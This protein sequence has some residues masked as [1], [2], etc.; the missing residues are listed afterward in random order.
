MRRPQESPVKSRQPTSDA[1]QV[2]RNTIS[3]WAVTIIVLLF[4]WSSLLQAFIIPSSSMES[5]L[6]VGDHVLVDRLCYAPAGT[7]SQH[8]LPYSKVRRG[9]IVVFRWPVDISQN[10]V[11]RAIGLPGDRLRIVNKQVY[12][13][14]KPLTEP[15]TQF[16]TSFIVPYRDNFPAEPDPSADQRAREMLEQ[17]VVNGELVIPAGKYFMMGDNRDNSLDSRYWGFVPADN[18]VGKPTIIFWSYEAPTEHLTSFFSLD[19]AI[20]L[21]QNFF[22]KTRWR[23]TLK[24]VRGLKI[25]D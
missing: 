22:T 11:K 18:I 4:C 16:I 5:T 17:N 12:I 21:A 7:L 15:Y 24:L 9:D 19:H 13:N 25:D 20:D 6:L 23:R 2:V 10:Y 3:E 1:N 14:G 8:L